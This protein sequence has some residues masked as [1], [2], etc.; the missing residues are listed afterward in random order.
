MGKDAPVIT[1]LHEL[2][3]AMKYIT[4]STENDFVAKENLSE[5]ISL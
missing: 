3:L 5:L 2:V 4:N 1:N